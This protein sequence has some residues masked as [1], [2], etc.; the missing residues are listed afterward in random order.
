MVMGLS[1]RQETSFE[2]VLD[3][4]CWPYAWCDKRAVVAAIQSHRTGG[5]CEDLRTV[6]HTDAGSINTLREQGVYS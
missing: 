2:A 4:G 6:R 3:D 1:A 5:Y